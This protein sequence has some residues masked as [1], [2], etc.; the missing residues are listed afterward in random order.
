MSNGKVQAILTFDLNMIRVA[1]ELVPR[2]LTQWQKEQRVEVGQ[3]LRQR[4]GN[5]P[6][7]MLSRLSTWAYGYE[8]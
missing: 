2:L 6:S 3:G 4:A 5:D 8:P 1:V 7:F